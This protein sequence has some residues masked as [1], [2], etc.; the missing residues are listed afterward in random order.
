M[1]EPTPKAEISESKIRPEDIVMPSSSYWPILLAFS[2]T[3]LL[4]G[5]AISWPF[6]FL[7]LLSS[8]VCTI[9]WLIEPPHPE[10]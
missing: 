7:G 4:A 6:V 1:A 3:L 5:L 2:L 10:H 8:L 9:G